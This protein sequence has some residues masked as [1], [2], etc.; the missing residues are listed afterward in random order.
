MIFKFVIAL[1]LGLVIQFSQVQAS[2]AAES[3]KSCGEAG[4]AMSCCEGLQSCPCAKGGDS[5]QKP[6]PLIPAALDL[7]TLLSKT[8]ESINLDALVS[9]RAE[10]IKCFATQTDPASGFAGV[11]LSVA[12]CRFLI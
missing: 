6:S 4:E 11:P 1:F 8:S 12:F 9:P 2:L 5:E 10:T 3:G 7:K